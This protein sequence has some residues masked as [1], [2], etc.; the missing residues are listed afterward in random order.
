MFRFHILLFFSHLVFTIYICIPY[1]A[2][3]IGIFLIIHTFIII[4]KNYKTL[5]ENCFFNSLIC[6]KKKKKSFSFSRYRSIFVC[7]FG[8]NITCILIHFMS[9]CE[10]TFSFTV[11]AAIV[12]TLHIFISLLKN[13]KEY[14]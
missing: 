13:F 7:L 11:K 12:L 5:K 6:I 8:K 4:I 14:R 1:R 2:N 9:K 10:H 3:E